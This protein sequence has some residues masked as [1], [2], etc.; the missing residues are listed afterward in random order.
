[1]SHC[2]YLTFFWVTLFFA[3]CGE[4]EKDVTPGYPFYNIS[5]NLFIDIHNLTKVGPISMGDLDKLKSDNIKEF[6]VATSELK[7][8]QTGNLISSETSVLA[9]IS[10]LKGGFELW[11][12][13]PVQ[14]RITHNIDGG[15]PIAPYPYVRNKGNY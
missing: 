11:Q 10:D 5:S 12:V 8:E 15:T 3:S 9:L 13:N 14:T 7:V 4:K 1:M 6:Y 2:R